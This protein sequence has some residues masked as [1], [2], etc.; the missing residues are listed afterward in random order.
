MRII[1]N[2][3]PK[4]FFNYVVHK[5]KKLPFY[6]IERTA[7]PSD[8]ATLN[9]SSFTH[10]VFAA[11]LGGIL[12]QDFLTFEAAMMVAFESCNEK[13]NNLI[14]IRV[15]LI[16][17]QILHT[18]HVPHVDYDTPHKTCLLYLNDSDGDTLI[19][20]EKYKLD[21]HL[22]SQEYYNT[23][24]KHKNMNIM[25]KSTPIANKMVIFDGFHYHSSSTPTN[26]SARFVININ[27]T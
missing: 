25:Y 1:E 27:Y 24:L 14:R 20:K 7:T 9:N 3:I 11:N 6:F 10:T 21:Q 17:P 16:T 2:A 13:I 15:G 22:N 5:V 12:S 4:D 8:E 26:T 19:Y 23:N 18:I